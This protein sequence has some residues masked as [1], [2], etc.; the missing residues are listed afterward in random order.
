MKYELQN[1]LSRKS[2][3]RF[4]TI[5]QTVA[6]YLRNDEKTSSA[7]EDTKRFKSEETE[8]LEDYITRNNFWI[9]GIDLSKY[10]SEGAEQKV[11]LQD[12]E[13]VLKFKFPFRSF[14]LKSIFLFSGVQLRLVF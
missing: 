5:I 10:V 4:G 1:I 14:T 7:I 8:R 6:S 13:H 9:N 11:Y 3:V 12:T 2:Q